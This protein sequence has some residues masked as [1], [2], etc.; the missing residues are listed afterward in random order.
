MAFFCGQALPRVGRGVSASFMVALND[1]VGWLAG[2][3]DVRMR[4][5]VRRVALTEF[6]AK[7]VAAIAGIRIR[8]VAPPNGGYLRASP[9]VRRDPRRTSARVLAFNR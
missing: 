3:P 2:S 1:H 4:T 6:S 5:Y 9:T 8:F 7:V